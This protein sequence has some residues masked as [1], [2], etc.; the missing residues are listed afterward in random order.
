MLKRVL[1][2][3]VLLALLVG[4]WQIVA[5]WVDPLLLS[6]PVE[7][8]R[9]LSRDHSLLL[10]EARVTAIEIVLGLLIAIVLGVGIAIAMHLVRPLKISAYPLLIVSQAIPVVSL[11]PLLVLAFGYGIGPKLAMVAVVCFFPIAINVAAGLGS[12]DVELLKLM[13]I[14]GASRLTRL[15]KAELPAALPF[16]FT[17]LKLAAVVASI[18]AVFGEWAGA[19]RG[20]GRLILLANNQ[21]Q[22]PRVYAATALLSAMA[23]ALFLLV[24]LVERFAVP[25]KGRT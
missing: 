23:I 24:V 1:P 21:L 10:D 22:T 18:G 13:R 8:V 5:G 3:A 19:E 4:V 15:R 11:A 6:S 16:F 12:V 2:P 20:L 14:L 17:G 25:W 9:A 7:T